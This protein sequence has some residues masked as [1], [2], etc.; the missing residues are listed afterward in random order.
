MDK[1]PGSG[2]ITIVFTKSFYH[3]VEALTQRNDLG[4][5]DT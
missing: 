1:I 4:F 5:V 3:I 2:N